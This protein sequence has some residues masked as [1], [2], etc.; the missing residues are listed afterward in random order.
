MTFNTNELS[1]NARAELIR[2]NAFTAEEWTLINNHA[3]KVGMTRN[4]VV[5]SL[6]NPLKVNYASYGDQVV[7]GYY[8][9]LRDRRLVYFPSYGSNTKA[10]AWN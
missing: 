1:K 10:T 2:R 6:G 3:I 5:C 8:D 4:A 7:F 9:S